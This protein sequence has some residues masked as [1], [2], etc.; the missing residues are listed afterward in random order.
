[1]TTLELVRRA[2]MPAHWF[3]KWFTVHAQPVTRAPASAAGSIWWGRPKEMVD[4]I[5]T[6]DPLTRNQATRRSVSPALDAARRSGSHRRHRRPRRD[7]RQRAPRCECVQFC[8]ATASEHHLNDGR[9]GCSVDGPGI[10]YHGAHVI[11]TRCWLF[12][13]SDHDFAANNHNNVASNNHHNS[14]GRDIGRHEAMT[15]SVIAPVETV[16]TERSFRAIG[17]TA[18]VVTTTASHA[19]EAEGI[20]RSEVEAIDLA[21]SRFRPDSE[22]AF[23]HANAGRTVDV[24]PLLFEALDVA[25]SVA[26]RT[27][28]A[29]DPTVGCAI[30]SLGYDR[31]FEEIQ[32]RPLR[33]TDLGPVPGFRHLHLD[34]TRRTARI[35]K[36][37]RLD[38]GS[39]TKALLADRAAAHVAKHL[40]SGV[41]ISIG[42]D[43][44]VAG[45]PPP[46]G[47]AIG[48]AVDSATGPDDVDEVVAI[49]HGGLASSSTEVRSWQMGNSHV[50]H[51]VDP[52]TGRSSSPYWRLVS[53]AGASC[54]EANALST[55]AIVWGNQAME[56]LR[57]FGQA[58]RLLRHDGQ[59]FTL[60]GW[61]D[62][63]RT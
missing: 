6:A 58:V 8:S 22:L 44:A 24:S 37:M 18:M 12:V 27:H 63:E 25:Y 62:E 54:V 23:L 52:A 5:H 56:R 39:S 55:A 21:C 26:E 20:L 42:G 48:I 40:G 53:A 46:E 32:S 31:Q 36:E 9:S 17:T 47:W 16:T 57:R 4:E 50:H 35:P 29:V 19:D 41:L 7:R 34:H 33:L 30:A 1:V 43:V 2:N 14:T 51:I 38:L 15:A 28:G 3:Q 11:G 49:R 10:A 61:P 45:E 13:A 60:G 59:V